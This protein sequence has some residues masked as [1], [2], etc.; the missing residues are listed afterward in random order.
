MGS[1]PTAAI[2]NYM[3][4]LQE[5]HRVFGHHIEE[6]PTSKVPDK[7]AILR[8]RLIHEELDELHDAMDDEDIVKIA[9]GLADLLYVVFG[10]AVSYGMPMDEIFDIVHRYN[11]SKLGPDGKPLV[12]AGGKSIKPD[13]W[14]PPDNEIR[15]LLKSKL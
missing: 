2:M 12:D 7:V 5:F 11:M 13:G 4:K 6:K 9:D 15:N 14:T 10:T 8:I 1:T 3:Q